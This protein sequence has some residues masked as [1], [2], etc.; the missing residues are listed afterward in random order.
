MAQ[1]RG[2]QPVVE[3]LDLKTIGP[4]QRMIFAL[5]YVDLIT[6][7]TLRRTMM[8]EVPT[9]AIDGVEIDKN[10]TP[11]YDEILAHRVSLAPI[12]SSR[13][14]KMNFPQGCV[15][16]DGC[17]RCRIPWTLEY[18]GKGLI[19]SD[20]IQ[21][22]TPVM[23]DGVGVLVNKSFVGDEVSMHGWVRKGIGKT[24]A[25]WNPLTVS[26][27][28]IEPLIVLDQEA[29]KPLK[30]MQRDD[31]LKTCR[32]NI[33]SFS[34]AMDGVED[35]VESKSCTLCNECVAQAKSMG[36]GPSELSRLVTV[37]QVFVFTIETTGVLPASKVLVEGL[38]IIRSK[39]GVSIQL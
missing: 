29:M 18:S 38:R 2:I 22:V 34:G 5:F 3:I 19:T 32:K 33:Y 15:C 16:K 31:L 25:K 30:P 28:N 23:E 7:N 10:T 11:M 27:F 17:P 24:H 1:G 6:A 14:G 20:L 21:G 39:L 9:L 8:S 36:L 37:E 4:R 35:L 13:V 26:I 12:E